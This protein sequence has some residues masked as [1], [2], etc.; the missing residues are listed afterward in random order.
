MNCLYLRYL[1]F[2]SFFYFGTE[3]REGKGGQ[4]HPEQFLTERTWRSSGSG[5]RRKGSRPSAIPGDHH[6]AH[7]CQDGKQMQDLHLHLQLLT[8]VTE[9]LFL[10]K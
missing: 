4:K 10:S 8:R 2:D 9:S 6:D 3:D 5:N 7:G 1:L